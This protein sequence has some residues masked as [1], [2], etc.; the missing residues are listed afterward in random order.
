LP[1]KS[2]KTKAW[3]EVSTN[4]DLTN[5]EIHAYLAGF[6]QVDHL[7]VL[8]DFVDIYFDSVPQLWSA[9]TH[10]IGQSLVTGLF[11]VAVVAQSVIDKADEFISNN[12][13]LAVGARRIIVEQRDSLA[14]ALRAQQK[15]S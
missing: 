12:P 14:R 6:H 8:K 11:P 15:D 2:D 5:S 10:E 4:T 7:S 1:S 9:R 3:V 13:D